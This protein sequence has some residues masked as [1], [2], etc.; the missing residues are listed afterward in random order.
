MRLPHTRAQFEVDMYYWMKGNGLAPLD[1]HEYAPNEAAANL[2]Y[3]RPPIESI[4]L[5]KFTR[6]TPEARA[7]FKEASRY[8]GPITPAPGRKV[9]T[10]D[11]YQEAMRKERSAKRAARLLEKEKGEEVAAIHRAKERQ[12]EIAEEAR[13]IRET[14]P[15]VLMRRDGSLFEMRIQPARVGMGWWDFLPFYFL[16]PD[17]SFYVLNVPLESLQKA[18]VDAGAALGCEFTVVAGDWGGWRVWR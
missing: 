6:H 5:A 16:I 9:R 17:T 4:D 18:V 8:D 7:R 13:R 2:S 3:E 14:I 12:L 10:K 1:V 11:E 15:L